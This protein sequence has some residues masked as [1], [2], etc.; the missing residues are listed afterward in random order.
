MTAAEAGDRRFQAPRGFVVTSSKCVGVGV[1]MILI[2]AAAA[3]HV[4][5]RKIFISKNHV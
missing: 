2:V 5:V 1:D 3:R 4:Q